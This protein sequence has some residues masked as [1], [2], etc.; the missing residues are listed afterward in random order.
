LSSALSTLLVFFTVFLVKFLSACDNILLK[1]K[2][3]I[4]KT[5]C[6]TA[7]EMLRENVEAVSVAFFITLLSVFLHI[8]S[9]SIVL[10]RVG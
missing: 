5:Y 8:G 9:H 7:S 1:D 3:I 10:D 4:V 2:L 6:Q